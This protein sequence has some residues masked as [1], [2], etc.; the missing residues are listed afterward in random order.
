M[1]V[2]DEATELVRTTLA[3]TRPSAYSLALN[4]LPAIYV[5]GGAM[6]VWISDGTV[7]RCAVTLAWLYLVPPLV[8]RLA[9]AAFGMPHGELLTQETR[10]YRV[11]WFLTQLQVVF[12]R[13]AF[14]EELLRLI[15]GAYPLWLNMWGAKVSLKVY[16][17]P[18]ALVVDRYALRVGSAVVVG[19]RSVLSAH[20]G[21]KDERG[22]FCVTL[23]PVEIGSGVLIGAYAGIGPGC[24][25]A[26]GEEVTAAAFLR[27]FTYW[28]HG[29]RV[30]QGTEK[31]GQT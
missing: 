5:A 29:Q 2:H 24:R 1:N 15:P 11:W 19:T 10:A 7:M 22:E 8:A 28:V 6:L 13:F 21:V 23:A 3:G 30:K 17:G 20:L 4:F 26:S 25:I 12:N 9:I 14:L 18:G 16:W 27:P 31:A